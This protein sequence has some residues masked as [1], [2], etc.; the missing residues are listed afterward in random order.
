MR[1]KLFLHTIT[2]KK[3]AIESRAQDILEIH[4]NFATKNIA[5]R[6]TNRP[7]QPSRLLYVDED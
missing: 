4:L 5:T 6:K 3:A 1:Q 7:F 2:L